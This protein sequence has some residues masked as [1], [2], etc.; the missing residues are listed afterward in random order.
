MDTLWQDLRYGVRMLRRNPGF[1]AVA[2]LTLAIGIGANIVIFSVVNGILLKPLPF[3]DSH[4]VVTI[5]ETDAN[6]N[7]TRGTA[8]AA[9]FLDWRDMNHV[10]QELSCWRA[11]YFTITGAGEPERV[12]GSQVSGN[13]FRMLRV[14]PILGRDFTS[15]DEQIGH[16]QVVILS[17]GLWQ[18]HYGADAAVLGK[19]ILLD[20]NPFT[21]VGVLPRT[22][23]L[24]GTLPEFELWKPFAF[25]RTQLNR[26]D[27]ELVIF[28]R[29]KDGVPVSQANAE[30]ITIQEQLKKQYPAFDQKIGIR[31]IGFHD[32]L[33]STLRPGLLLLLAAV[34]FVLLIACANVANLK[35]A[36]AA[37]RE[38]EIALRVSLGAGRRRIF[39]QLL[40]ESA[41]LSFIGAAI[42]VLFAYGGIHILRDA[43][44][45]GQPSRIP[46]P[47][48]IAIDA[49]VLG[50]TVLVALVTGILFGF[51][52]AIQISRS[53]LFESLKEGSRGTTAGRH[54]QLARS[55]LV[56]SEVAFSLMLLVGAGLLVRSFALMLAEPLGFDPENLLTAQL[57]LPDAHYPD[58][59]HISNFYQSVL[60]RVNAI[61][62][63][64]S[65]GAANFLPLTHWT[66]FCDFDIAGRASPASG[67][68]FT[69][70]YR[71]ADWR[72]LST[73][74]VPVKEGREFT[75]SDGPDSQAVA[76]VNET[77]ARRYWPNTDPVGQQIRLIFNSTR[78]PWDA[79]PHQGWLTIV[80]VVG[81][82]RDWAW[83]EPKSGQLY[84]LQTQNPSRLMSLMVRSRVDRAQLTGAV[85]RAVESVDPDQPI[86]DVKTME[87]YLAVAFSQRRLNMSLLAFFAI[88][89]A[90]LAAIGI[91]GVM[92]YAVTQRSHEIGIR[93]AL[94]AEPGDVLRMIVGD[95]M[96]LALL[97]L[98]IGLTASL[99]LM[100]YLESQLY[101][102]KARDPLTFISVAAGLALVALAACYFPARRA[103]KVDPL[104]A[105]RYE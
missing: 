90:L 5:W 47:E 44:V 45:S 81:D 46:H 104:V 102:V 21:V 9:E 25:D 78:T 15:E 26:E 4:R 36:R 84:L 37:V 75:S 12:W 97:G 96:K 94:G 41:L 31:V 1:A 79:I 64:N 70:E 40:T 103:T 65:A 67:E 48:W 18:R 3:P 105:L 22:F 100:K 39:R 88:V 62:G 59:P 101:G 52:P 69:S 11:L 71:V 23:S 24:Y 30:M 76:L 32:E 42:G 57:L 10:F 17:Y 86:T 53:A 50:F 61:P 89:A 99:L 92:G 19:T 14:T 27:H 55:V 49:T 6:R 35:L 13:F 91:Y 63:V 54:N 20:G 43:V 51:A 74:G 33:V 2:I 77:L 58:G 8:S 56:V 73:M 29:L 98:I 95:G 85:R 80:G 34:A 7:V 28:G 16:E 38:R 82:I 83:S 93:M 72:Y 66:H 68:H 60:E 87:D